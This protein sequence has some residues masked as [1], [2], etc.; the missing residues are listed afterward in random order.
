MVGISKSTVYYILTE[1]LD[2]ESCAQEGCHENVS[3]EYLLMF[4]RNKTEFFRGF[5]NMDVTWI[6]H[7]THETKKLSKQWH[8]RGEL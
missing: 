6:H 3:V 7:F 1:N 5:I 4:H 2:I 8:E